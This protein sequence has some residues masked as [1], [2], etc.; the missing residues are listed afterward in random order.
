VTDEPQLKK[1][2][3]IKANEIELS[4]LDI[5]GKEST[6]EEQL[7]KLKQ[8]KEHKHLLSPLR[9]KSANKHTHKNYNEDAKQTP[10]SI[11]PLPFEADCIKEQIAKIGRLRKLKR[12][13]S[14][15]LIKASISGKKK[16]KHGEGSFPL[17][18]A[19]EAKLTLTPFTHTHKPKKQ[20][21]QYKGIHSISDA[22]TSI[23]KPKHYKCTTT[24]S[25]DKNT[26]LQNL[27]AWHPNLEIIANFL[28]NPVKASPTSE[29]MPTYIPHSQHKNT[30]NSTLYPKP[31]SHENYTNTSNN[32]NNTTTTTAHTQSAARTHRLNTKYTHN[33]YTRNIHIIQHIHKYL[34]NSKNINA[35]SPQT[36]SLNT[37]QPSPT[38]PLVYYDPNNPLS[39]ITQTQTHSHGQI[40]TQIQ[41]YPFQN[42]NQEPLNDK[43]LREKKR[44]CVFLN[45][46]YFLERDELIERLVKES[47]YQYNFKIKEKNVEN[48]KLSKIERLYQMKKKKDGVL[49]AYKKKESP[50]KEKKINK[51]CLEI[52]NKSERKSGHKSPQRK[53]N[54]FA[55]A[56][57]NP[58]NREYFWDY[59]FYNKKT[60][61][62]S[63]NHFNIPRDTK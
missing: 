43:F 11:T 15:P 55:A 42:H 4:P 35:F 13:S 56:E 51:I 8:K 27:Q 19:L 10:S 2:K 50:A 34:N 49:F 36:E 18:E 14:T 29:P 31:Q 24:S 33:S 12:N 26:N 9:S 61:L 52:I 22:F 58:T 40:Q 16:Q 60:N 48:G 62:N 41:T 6:G 39:K 1:L 44:M 57:D 21:K 17:S 5:L 30:P 32:F 46:I 25:L 45:V 38:T 63:F 7:P 20:I 47:N 3:E 23:S 53:K 54:D 59:N 37:I 28:R